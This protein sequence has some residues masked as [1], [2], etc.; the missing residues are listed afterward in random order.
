[1]ILFRARL[2]LDAARRAGVVRSLVRV[3][4]PTQAMPGCV[5]SRL[6]VDVED[7]EVL[8]FVEEWTDEQHLAARLRADSMR[9]VLS[10]LD[11]AFEAPEVRFET[12]AGTRG[13]EWIAE[14]RGSSP[15]H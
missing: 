8:V 5:S 2:R 6:Y 14:C 11:C 9:V 7:E 4:G 15:L 10:A 13:I 1:M 3:L 12:I